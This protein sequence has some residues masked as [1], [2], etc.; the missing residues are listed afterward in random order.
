MITIPNF[1]IDSDLV[2]LA[3]TLFGSPTT[4]APGTNY[5]LGDT[6]IP[7]P[8]FY[9]NNPSFPTNLMFQLVA[10]VGK[11]SGLQPS[12]PLT[13]GNTVNDNQ[14]QWLAINSNANPPALPFDQ[15]YVISPTI[16]IESAQ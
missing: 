4:W 5:Q 12:F 15:Y 14:I 3:R 7:T 8:T 11:S 9:T 1:T 16:T 6:V 10:F 13:V 2:W